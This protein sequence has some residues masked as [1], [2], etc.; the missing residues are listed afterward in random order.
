MLFVC[1][2][3]YTCMYTYKIMSVGPDKAKD[4]KKL[5]IK[6]AHLKHNL[7]GLWIIPSCR[8]SW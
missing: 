8:H 5:L 1:Q 6:Q 2:N 3:S 7:N 4:M